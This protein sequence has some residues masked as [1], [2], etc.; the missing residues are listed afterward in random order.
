MT[1]KK[2][3]GMADHLWKD[4]LGIFLINSV[5]KAA[6]VQ[7]LLLYTIKKPVDGYRMPVCTVLTG[8]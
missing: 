2:G 3:W 7:D 8:I 5:M 4:T 1:S 6:S